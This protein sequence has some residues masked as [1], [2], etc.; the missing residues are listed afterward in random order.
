MKNENPKSKKRNFRITAVAVILLFFAVICTF[1]AVLA[2]PGKTIAKGVTVC[3]IDLSGM[4]ELEAQAALSKDDGLSEREITLYTMLGKE[5][6]F[7]GADI[8]LSRDAEK[9]AK[10]AFSVGRSGNMLENAFT[11]VKLHFKPRNFDYICAYDT[12]KLSEIIYSFGV[13]LN[14]EQKKY[15]LEYGGDSVSVKRGTAGQSKDLSKAIASFNS[16]VGSDAD[17]IFI[18][19]ERDFPHIPDAQS[20]YDE[21]YMSPVDASYKITEAGVELIPEVIGRQIDAIEAGTQIEKLKNGETIEL[22]LI[23]LEPEMTLEELKHQLFNHVLSQYSTSYPASDK[24]R[25]T[26][27]E[28]AA[29]KI[30]EVILAPGAIFSFNETV[31]ARTKAAGFR[32][33]PVFVNGESVQGTGGGVCQVSSTLYSAVLY[34]DLKITER[35]NHSMTVAYVPK[36]QD[37]TV[38]YGTLD[39][40]FENSTAYPIKITTTAGGGKIT[41]S[42]HGTK[43]AAEK[44]VKIVNNIIETKEPTVE[45]I[46]DKTLPVGSKKVLSKGKTGYTVETTRIVLENGKEVKSEK[47]GRSVYK[48]VPTKVAIGAK[49]PAPLPTLPPTPTPVPEPTP[50][51]EVTSEP[52]TEATQ[53]P[54]PTPN[55]G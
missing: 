21:I 12:E 49:V 45:E 11:L 4:T 14:G 32:E 28:L 46:Q 3:G 30:D 18:Q 35:R 40:K 36:G 27:V 13:S 22:K 48:M 26:N 7:K 50:E 34:A 1:F 2:S 29:A 37:A 43:P 25:S 15:I 42:I 6:S 17:R 51:A 9:T 24:S 47:M 5:V 31:G 23:W 53:N 20:L 16:A 44:T 52:T 39:F 38:S 55:V 33:A 54:R 8:L 19:L 41:V 10:A